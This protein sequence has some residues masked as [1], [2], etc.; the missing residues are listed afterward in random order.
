[1]EDRQ[2]QQ[3]TNTSPARQGR[4]Y[5]DGGLYKYVKVPV[6]VVEYVIIALIAVLLFCV[7]FG[8][9]TGGY[10]VTFDAMGGT[11]V[12]PQKLEYGDLVAEPTPPTMEGHTF[13]GWFSDEGC[14]Y[15][16]DFQNDTVSGSITLYAGW[17]E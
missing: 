7:I 11:R 10:T 2:Q 1:M 3:Q 16:W 6:R 5:G 12:E 13:I 4:Y 17:T 15:A 8:A 9:A 14:T